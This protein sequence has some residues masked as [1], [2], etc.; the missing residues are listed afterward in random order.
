MDRNIF[1]LKKEL[2]DLYIEGEGVRG[3]Y[4]AKDNRP[5]RIRLP[6]IEQQ[7]GVRRGRCH[8]FI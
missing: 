3:P 8:V 2:L 7:L 1:D 6:E 5:F 4:R